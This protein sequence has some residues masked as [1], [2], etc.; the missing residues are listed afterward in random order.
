MVA[1]PPAAAPRVPKVDT[2]ALAGEEA[3]HLLVAA[4]LRKLR[5]Q[6]YAA[7]LNDKQ[8]QAQAETVWGHA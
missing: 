7:M 3:Q 2:A 6:M 5:P 4:R 8:A 1:V